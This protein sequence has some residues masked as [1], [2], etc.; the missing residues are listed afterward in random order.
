[1]RNEGDIEADW[2][3]KVACVAFAKNPD[4]IPVK[5]RLARSLGQKVATRVYIALLEDC[6]SS[7]SSV[8]GAEKFLACLPD[9]RGT[10]FDDLKTRH[11]VKLV[12]QEGDDLGERMLHCVR[13]LLKNYQAVI[14]FGTDIPALPVISIK[15]ALDSMRHWDVLLGPSLDGGYYAFGAKKAVDSM[16]VGIEWGSETV[17]GDTVKNCAGL[18]LELMFLDVLD[19]V[20]N[21]ESLIRLSR[22]LHQTGSRA[23]R[24]RWVLQEI[25]LLDKE[26]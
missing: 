23:Y 9:E 5:T 7:L 16:F 6:L 26:V 1:M 15:H 19:D 14:V 20:D 4:L 25:G 13:S 18:G 17:F 3:G 10:F 2:H 12:C 11:G 24:T 8:N 21:I 22:T